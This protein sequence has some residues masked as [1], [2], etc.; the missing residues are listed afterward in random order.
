MH[1]QPILTRVLHTLQ[2]QVRHIVALLPEA[3]GADQPL[4][5]EAVV[6]HF[7]ESEEGRAWSFPT[8]YQSVN[9][10]TD[11][12]SKAPLD[13]QTKL[14]VELRKEPVVVL[15]Y[16][17]KPQT[18]GWMQHWMG[19]LTTATGIRGRHLAMGAQ[20]TVSYTISA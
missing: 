17:R 5:E 16:V 12:L 19:R 9:V 4:S 10:E 20:L 1:L 18:S 3:L 13:M 6:R 11:P 8:L 15:E 14:T 7:Q 2:C